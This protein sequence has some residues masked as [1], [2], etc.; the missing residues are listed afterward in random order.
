MKT[1]K[2]SS[3]TVN[4]LKT[5]LGNEIEKREI[6]AIADDI[7]SDYAP[8]KKLTGSRSAKEPAIYNGKTY[9]SW[10]AV[11]VENNFPVDECSSTDSKGKRMH[12]QLIRAYIKRNSK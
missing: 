5:L 3:L 2:L 9:K 12:A 10:V 1:I 8:V 6:S 11:A 4:E 7:L